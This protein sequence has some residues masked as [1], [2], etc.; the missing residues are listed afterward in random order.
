MRLINLETI[1]LWSWLVTCETKNELYGPED[2]KFDIDEFIKFLQSRFNDSNRSF[3][4][5]P[6]EVN[7]LDT[8]VKQKKVLV[9][10]NNNF[11]E[12]ILKFI[13]GLEQSGSHISIDE[14]LYIPPPHI[15][16]LPKQ[17]VHQPDVSWKSLAMGIFLIAL[18]I[19]PSNRL[20]VFPGI[21]IIIWHFSRQKHLKHAKSTNEKVRKGPE[22]I[23]T[24]WAKWETDT[25]TPAL[26]LFNSY[27]GR[28][29]RQFV[30]DID[31]VLKVDYKEKKLD[32]RYR[33]EKEH[34]QKTIKDRIN[35]LKE[36]NK[37]S[38]K[39]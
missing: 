4:V 18:S 9:R 11:N 30:E 26:E 31:H 17:S 12:N 29:S 13:I 27:F 36:E 39:T 3:S 6:C 23:K 5:E 21:F 20:L 19:T 24:E 32:F 35:A 33:S 2:F 25:L 22:S 14:K 10:F 34:S 1:N 15:P 38:F 8:N 28:F 16:D 7:F 37:K